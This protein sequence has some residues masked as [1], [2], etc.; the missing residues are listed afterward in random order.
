ME[1]RKG[2]SGIFRFTHLWISFD[3]LA[4]KCTKLRLV[5][6]LSKVVSEFEDNQN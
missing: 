4:Q 5:V 2:S 6:G 3:D 1:I